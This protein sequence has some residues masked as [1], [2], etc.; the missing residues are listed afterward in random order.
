MG[1]PHADQLVDFGVIGSGDDFSSVFDICCRCNIW[2]FLVGVVAVVPSCWKNL[3]PAARARLQGVGPPPRVS[4]HDKTWKI[5]RVD[6]VERPTFIHESMKLL[7][8]DR[9]NIYDQVYKADTIMNQIDGQGSWNKKRKRISSFT[10]S[11][12]VKYKKI[13]VN[14]ITLT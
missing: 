2:C 11:G 9:E 13:F 8:C 14:L 3:V 5:P 1:T 6:F 4:L 10:S 7:T 12:R